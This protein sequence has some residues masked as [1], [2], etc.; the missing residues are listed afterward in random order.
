MI[1]TASDTTPQDVTHVSRGPGVS[2][3]IVVA[4]IVAGLYVGRDVF[5]P[6]ALAILLSFVL[7]PPVER[8]EIV[9]VPR[10]AAVPIVVVAAFLAIFALGSLIASQITQLADG[11]PG[12]QQT[13]Q[14]KIS[15][16][17][18][19]TTVGPLER[20]ASV[21]QDLGKELNK[22]NN[23]DVEIP[24][25]TAQPDQTR[26]IPVEVRTPPP[27]ALEN[28]AS[29]ISPLLHPL[30]TVG[31]VVIFVVFILFQREDLRNRMIKLAGAHDLQ[32]TTSAIND[33]TGRL[34]RLFL[35]QLGLN[36]AFGI[37]IGFGLSIIG[38]PSAILWGI[39]AGI[40][41]FV[42]YIGAFVAAFFP[43]TLAIA[44]DPGWSMLIWTIG[45]IIVADVLV[46]H[47]I[48][49]MLF[50]R[51]SGLSPFAVVVSATFWT[52]LWGPIGL[53][54]ATPMTICLVVLGHH[55]ESMKFFDIL[56]GDRPALSPPE[57]F[58]QRMLAN[59]PGEAVEKAEEYLKER[60]LTEYYEEVALKGLKLAQSDLKRD[61]LP[62]A[63]LG[64]I[65]DNIVDL[66]EDLSDEIDDARI[67]RT[68]DVE[69]GAALE[70]SV[71]MPELPFI[72]REGL[73]AEW[74]T[75]HPVLCVAERS[76]LDEAAARILVQILSKHG[77]GARVTKKEDISSSGIF[78]LNGDGVALICVSALDDASP[79]YTRHVVRKLRRK[80]PEA[81]ILV[82]YWMAGKLA[83]TA[84]SI[85]A[86]TIATSLGGAAKYCLDLAQP[87]DKTSE[88]PASSPDVVLRVAG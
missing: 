62:L 40:M 32:A 58:Y 17:R 1:L 4:L 64:A 84:E 80:I 61:R 77:L 59:D 60:T 20:A 76:D 14:K 31:V 55:V 34:S 21:L 44:V 26:P 6:I 54:L 29:L 13:M 67:G 56:L 83:V 88:E 53:V 47:V 37:V 45:L 2:T 5:V 78:S 73:P 3:A 24:R 25:A 18:S 52:A 7:T 33:A 85:K 66:I 41:R 27:T 30:A 68:D 19:V 35:S 39:L 12:Y 87:D 43:L 65:R 10:G 79:T 74:Q 49:P 9:R 28:V 72:I 86:D 23:G 71:P 16:L 69:A 48:E 51:S 15:S 75:E 42:P 11:L 8:L 50:G 82:C 63:R 36:T 22:P 70:A 38:V 46:G 57:I 81:K